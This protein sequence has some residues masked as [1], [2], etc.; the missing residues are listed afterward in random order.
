MKRRC[1]A[2]APGGSEIMIGSIG[3]K[4]TSPSTVAPAVGRAVAAVAVAAAVPAAADAEQAGGSR[5]PA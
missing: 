1:R 2:E 4:A 5:S 3:T